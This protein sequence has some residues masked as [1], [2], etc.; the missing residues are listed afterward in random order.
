MSMD[1]IFRQAYSSDLE[2]NVK[3]IKEELGMKYGLETINTLLDY[4]DGSPET[5]PTSVYEDYQNEHSSEY[6]HMVSSNDENNNIDYDRG[7][8]TV[9]GKTYSEE[10]MQLLHENNHIY[11]IV[12]GQKILI[13]WLDDYIGVPY[14]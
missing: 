9:D 12:N 3:D 4:W 6:M 2:E 10:E 8:I 14:I 1:E 11:L 5:D 13:K 7:T